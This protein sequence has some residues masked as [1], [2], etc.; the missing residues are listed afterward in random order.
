MSADA[1][2]PD[3]PD[4]HPLVV[5]CIRPKALPR[6]A[7]PLPTRNWPSLKRFLWHLQGASATCAARQR[8]LLHVGGCS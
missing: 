1:L 7:H 8:L 2:D 4:Q 6:V 5:R 3:G